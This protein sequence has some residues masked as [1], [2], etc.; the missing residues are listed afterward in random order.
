MGR[1]RAGGKKGGYKREAGVEKKEQN[2]GF[3]HGSLTCGDPGGQ[4]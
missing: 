2:I 1:V 3:H 4:G